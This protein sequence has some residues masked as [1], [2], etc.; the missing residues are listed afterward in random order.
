MSNYWIERQMTAKKKISEKTEADIKR[1]LS[2]Y[3]SNAMKRTIADF[4][5]TCDKLLATVEEGRKP[6]PADLHKLDK[7]WQS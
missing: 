3:Y 6:T 5:A 7:Y 1:Q 4:E 2:K